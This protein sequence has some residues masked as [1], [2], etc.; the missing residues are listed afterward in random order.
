MRHRLALIISVFLFASIMHIEA[1]STMEML[2]NKE[3][4]E[5]DLSKMQTRHDFY[6][7]F[8]GTQ[9]FTVGADEDGNTK[10]RVQ[11]YY[12]SN[13]KTDIFDDTKV[14][15]RRNGKYIVL[16]GKKHG[17]YTDAVCMELYQL[18]DMNMRMG[19]SRQGVAQQHCYVVD[20]KYADLTD[21]DPSDDGTIISTRD[22]L[23]DK[24]WYEVDLKTGKRKRTEVR[25]EKDGMA[26]FCTMAENYKSELPDWQMR[27]FYFSDNIEREFKH[28]KIGDRVNGIY[29]V[30]KER[31]ADG[32]W[33]AAN[34]DIST[35]S[36]N[37]LVLDCVYPQGMPTRVFMTRS[38]IETSHRN[39]QKAQ[40]WQL[41]ENVWHRLD[42]TGTKRILFTEKF[43]N[44]NVT[45]TFST[46]K[47]GVR[48]TFELS[49]PYYFS[50]TED[51]IFN[52]DKVGRATEGDYIVVNERTT[53]E[54][55]M[56]MSYK[57]DYLDNKNMLLSA[58]LDSVEH[59]IAYERDLSQEEQERVLANRQ[60]SIKGK[61]TLD[62]LSG[63]Q[64]R[65]AKKPYPT[66]SKWHR[67]YF[68]DSLW[69]DVDF[70]YDE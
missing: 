14:G 59:V 5:I 70:V 10:A 24:M 12:L 45:R 54:G 41:T 19:N 37:R 15:K 36:A 69:A 40:Q 26:L 51:S 9:R 4:Y 47:N 60:D 8:T 57:V 17:S 7:K 16:Q 50:N 58:M 34:Y 2:I 48:D 1:K 23:I 66:M 61:T 28:S 18:D 46:I 33:F 13:E 39:I 38:G 22:L 63:R 25:Y 32:K 65:F 56:A 29:L 49:N 68:T 62:R 67:W 6:I 20:S 27:E 21:N 64:W 3:W 44:I 55:R 42:S 31:G 53:G 11:S 52:F 30:V 35:L 43:D